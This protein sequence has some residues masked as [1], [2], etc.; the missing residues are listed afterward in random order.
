MSRRVVGLGVPL[1]EPV[2][3]VARPFLK[4]AALLKPDTFHYK[5]HAEALAQLAAEGLVLVGPLAEAV[6]HVQSREP[7][8]QPESH[9]EQAHRVPATRE[10]HEQ[11]LP[12]PDEAGLARRL[13]RDL[14][15]YSRA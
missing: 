2:A 14:H 6:V 8:A 10:Q 1:G 13:E 15:S 7:R 3:G 12:L 5:P 9:L 11:R 4:G